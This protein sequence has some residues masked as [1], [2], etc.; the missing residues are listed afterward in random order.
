MIHNRYAAFACINGFNL[1]PIITTRRS[2]K[3]ANYPFGPSF[4]TSFSI[5]GNY[6]AKQG[7]IVD[8]ATRVATSTIVP[9]LAP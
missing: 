6:G 5:C 8:V 7:T 3:I 4:R 1:S 2:G 9:C